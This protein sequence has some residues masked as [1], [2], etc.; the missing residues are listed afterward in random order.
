MFVGHRISPT[1]LLV[2][3][4]LSPELYTME[5]LTFQGHSQQASFVS[6][7][8]NPNDQSDQLAIQ[9]AIQLF[10]VQ[11]DLIP[12]HPALPPVLHPRQYSKF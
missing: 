6:L 10:D 9:D 3:V 4:E 8:S 11:F 5:N 12:T 1:L 7:S 2:S